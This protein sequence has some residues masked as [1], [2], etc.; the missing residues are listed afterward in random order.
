SCRVAGPR[1]PGHASRLVHLGHRR[2][3]TRADRRCA[4]LNP[5]RTPPRPH[6]DSARA[7]GRPG[8]EPRSPLRA[9]RRDHRSARRLA[10]R[11][12]LSRHLPSA[13]GRVRPLLGRGLSRNIPPVR[14]HRRVFPAEGVP[15][16]R[17]EEAVREPRGSARAY[18]QRVHRYRAIPV[19]RPRST[20]RKTSEVARITQAGYAGEPETRRRRSAR[21]DESRSAAQPDRY[22][23]TVSVTST[24]QT[25]P[26]TLSVAVEYWADWP[27]LSTIESLVRN[28]LNAG[29]ATLAPLLGTLSID[30]SST[31]RSSL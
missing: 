13:G 15:S 7:D 23:T 22:F 26:L 31:V 12:R 21:S 17:L 20:L 9:P 16:E 29:C 27:S 4:G 6:A 28:D 8:H 2:R 19:A 24:F 5:R 11:R 14:T 10:A 18:R 1:R 3:R 25:S 30:E